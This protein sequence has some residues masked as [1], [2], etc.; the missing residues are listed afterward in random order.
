MNPSL[1]RS[2]LGTKGNV[3]DL[4]PEEK[5]KENEA[6]VSTLGKVLNNLPKADVSERNPST[7]TEYL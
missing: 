3:L 4:T 6:E 5:A 7:D 2:V 1:R